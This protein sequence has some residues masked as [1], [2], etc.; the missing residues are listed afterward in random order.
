MIWNRERRDNMSDEE[1]Y[2]TAA[3]EAKGARMV[4]LLDHP[5]S[6][7]LMATHGIVFLKQLGGSLT[8]FEDYYVHLAEGK[9]ESP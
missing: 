9:P 7:E 4:I 2:E 6:D 1:F 5:M 3:K 8:P